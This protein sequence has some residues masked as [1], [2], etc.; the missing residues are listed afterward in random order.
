MDRAAARDAVLQLFTSA[1]STV[2]EFEIRYDDD[3]RT[4]TP[5][6]P[7][8]RLGMRHSGGGDSSIGGRRQVSRGFVFAQI[9]TVPGDGLSLSDDVSKTVRDTVL[10]GRKSTGVLLRNVTAVEAGRV[11]GVSQ[12]NVMADFEYDDVV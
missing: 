2:P 7:W 3:Q 8:A 5:P 4:D 6:P 9:F 11:S 12:V 10:A 1:F